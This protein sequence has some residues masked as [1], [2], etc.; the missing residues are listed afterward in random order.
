MPVR[1]GW[2]T[3][4]LA[5]L[6]CLGC[7]VAAII[8]LIEALRPYGGTVQPQRSDVAAPLAERANTP[9]PRIIRD[10]SGASL[11]IPH[12]P[13]RIISQTLG[14][15]EILLAICAPQRLV[16]L[17][18]LVDDADYSN[19][20][21]QAH[22][23]KARANADAEQ[24]LALYPDVIFV[25]SYSKAELIELLQA[26]RAPV[27]RFTHFDRL[28]D[29]KA[30]IRTIGYAV[31]EDANADALVQH[32]EHHLAQI[33][34]SLPKDRQPMRVLSYAQG[35]ST[36]G[37]HTLFD[38]MLQ[39][40]G[41]INLAAEQG[42]T[43]FRQISSEQLVRWNPDVIISSADRDAL[44]EARLQLLRDP[45]VAVTKA[46]KHQRVIVLPN[47]LFLTVTHHITQGIEQLARELY[48]EPS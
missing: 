5:F 19:V 10:A 22:L 48:D 29:I 9:F 17:S 14:T 21:A 1:Y 27:F 33:Q 38:D 30:N 37:A 46:G 42:L 11:V 6:M 24:I 28:E 40:V 26:A 25:A 31:G 23:V 3:R 15:D 7:G 20:T 12:K 41:V 39:A 2:L 8:V 43:G 18:I 45:A 35:G 44:P 13:Q 4:P 36:A 32:M 47:H 16:A 34:A